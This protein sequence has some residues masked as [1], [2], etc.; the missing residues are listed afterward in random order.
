MASHIFRGPLIVALLAGWLTGCATPIQKAPSTPSMVLPAPDVTPLDPVEDYP[1]VALDEEILFRI[2]IGDVAA[3]RGEYV[4]AFQAWMDLAEKTGDARVARR[5]FEVA[6]GSGQMDE[7]IVAVKR[8]TVLAPK[9]EQPQQLLL[10]LLIRT[11]RIAEAEPYLME[12]LEREPDKLG[13]AIVQ[14]PRIWQ[15]GSDQ[16]AVLHVHQ[17]I[18]E[19]YPAMPEAHFALAVMLVRQG[20]DADA[21]AALDRALQLRPDWES[22]QLYKAQLLPIAERMAFLQ[23]PSLR[24]NRAAQLLLASS[25]L[26]AM[27]NTEARQTYDAVLQKW[28][29]DIEAL[30]GAGLLAQY[31]GDYVRAD[32]LFKRGLAQNPANADHLR[33]YLAQSA[34]MR[35]QYREALNWYLQV[36]PDASLK[37]TA[38]I[39][40][41]Q[42]R[43][44]AADEAKALVAAMPEA[45]AE[46]KLEKIQTRAQ[47]LRE[48]KD[49]QGALQLLNEAVAAMPEAYEL[50][51]ERS[52]AADYAGDYAQAEA[53][54]RLY[55]SKR[56]DDASALNALGYT[57]ANRFDRLFEA[58]QLIDRALASDPENA[59]F[60]DSLGWL[61]FR[62][63]RY[64]EA[65]VLLA[66]AHA[67]FPDPEVSAHYAEALWRHGERA[68]ARN[69]LDA[70]LKL[71]PDD[72]GL[73]TLKKK[74]GL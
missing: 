35:L 21:I 65:V 55:L 53:D 40:R 9:S 73:L 2:L 61:R 42:A 72:D 26:E 23:K 15:E 4:L 8:W 37:I 39:A 29:D 1:R 68:K 24:Q 32:T 7:A 27:R 67:R 74:L 52:L 5:A 60:I 70:A 13:A 17:T 59:A 25:Q 3:Q 12:L 45:N 63:G 43:L 22:A 18:I 51:L 57:L 38:R 56:P 48:L 71:S 20:R 34:E 62:Q 11:N 6:I 33:A 19:R 64:A 10:A 44:G 49:H 69:V 16:A 58:E 30:T 31:V 28:P 14:M 54:L 46:Q 66:K 47:V 41:L 36:G 50:L